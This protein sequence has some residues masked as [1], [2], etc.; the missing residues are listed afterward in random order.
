MELKANDILLFVLIL[1]VPVY[2]FMSN[3]SQGNVLDNLKIMLGI[4][5]SN[6]S[7]LLDINDSAISS[8]NYKNVGGKPVV[9]IVRDKGHVTGENTI[10]YKPQYIPKDCLLYTS[11]SPRDAHE[12]RMPS[13]A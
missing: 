1:A 13:S 4:K 11:P 9:N 5:V 2:L 8:T 6:K 7:R 12:S 10:Y 3:K